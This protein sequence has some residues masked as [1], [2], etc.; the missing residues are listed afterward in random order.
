MI[1]H[2]DDLMA[3]GIDSFKVEGRM[4]SELYAATV[5]GA[6]RRA[7]DEWLEDPEIYRN[8]IDYLKQELDKC[9]HRLYSTGFFYGKPSESAQIYESSTYE[10]EYTYLGTA[11][12]VK[13]GYIRLHQKNKFSVGDEIEILSP[14]RAFRTCRVTDM[15]DEDGAAMVSCPHPKQ[16][17][18]IKT[19]EE[20]SAGDVLRM[21]TGR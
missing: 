17:F 4:K 3:S 8:D 20:A 9:T 6:Y 12:S 13:D 7:I 18:Y 21:R 5:A 10:K 15:R 11:E 19:S 2:M 1:E 14:G 16:E